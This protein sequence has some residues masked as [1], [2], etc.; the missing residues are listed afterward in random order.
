MQRWSPWEEKTATVL[1]YGSG[2]CNCVPAGAPKKYS[3]QCK[4]KAKSDFKLSTAASL[5]SRFPI[6]SPQA[7]IVAGGVVRA[8]VRGRRIFREFPADIA[9]RLGHGYRVDRARGFRFMS[10]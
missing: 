10:S 5:S 6:V 1:R 4:D 7:D 2:N 9:N 8:R 3:L